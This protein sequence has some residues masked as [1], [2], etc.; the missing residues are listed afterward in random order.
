MVDATYIDE[1]VV[2]R[3]ARCLSGSSI[4]VRLSVLDD[5]VVERC[6][7]Q[8]CGGRLRAD[9]RGGLTL[10][11]VDLELGDSWTSLTILVDTDGGVAI[12]IVVVVV[13]VVLDILTYITR[14][15][16]RVF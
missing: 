3:C 9:S 4:R 8:P 10:A 5:R 15:R 12:V 14:S 6:V 13:I 2:G 16:G 7:C 11:S 1:V